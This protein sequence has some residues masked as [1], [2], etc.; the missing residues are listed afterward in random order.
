MAG[1]VKAAQPVRSTEVTT[2]EAVSETTAQQTTQAT[3]RQPDVNDDLLLLVNDRHPLPKEYKANVVTLENEFDATVDKRAAKDLKQMLADCR[4]AG[5]SPLVCSSYRSVEKQ[6]KLFNNK[7]KEY[8]N[9]GYSKADA[10]KEAK[11]WV[12]YPETS[13]HHTGLAVDITDIDYQILD[14]KQMQMGIQRWLMENCKNY[15][16]ILRYPK[17][18]KTITHIEFEPWHYRYVGKENAI[19]IYDSGLCLEEYLEKTN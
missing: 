1:C 11:K 16:F 15:G 3:T 19:K 18:K 7:V 13:E 2:V 9:N 6:T 8:M 4:A 14:E 12:A 17:E 10:E 5:Y